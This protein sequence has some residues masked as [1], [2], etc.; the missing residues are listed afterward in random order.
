MDT[1][2][3]KNIIGD[4]LR[5]YREHVARI[6]SREDF[7]KKMREAFAKKKGPLDKE[8]KT[9]RGYI[10]EVENGVANPTLDFIE[11]FVDACGV[12]MEQFLRGFVPKDVKVDHQPFHQMLDT[13]LNSEEEEY[14]IGIKANLKALSQTVVRL[15]GAREEAGSDEEIAN[16]P[17]KAKPNQVGEPTREPGP[18]HVQKKRRTAL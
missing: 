18:A 1:K 5:H 10:T 11:A 8:K 4:K 12:S 15:R 2:A 14:I 6:P 9:S 7:A 16:P 17:P 13:I 3:G